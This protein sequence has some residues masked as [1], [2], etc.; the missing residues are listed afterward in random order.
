MNTDNV[1][2]LLDVLECHHRRYGAS[3]ISA[4][5][6]FAPYRHGK[7]KDLRA[8]FG[9]LVAHGGESRFRCLA[10]NMHGNLRELVWQLEKYRGSG[11]WYAAAGRLVSRDDMPSVEQIDAKI[12]SATPKEWIVE[13]RGTPYWKSP[14]PPRLGAKLETLQYET[15]PETDLDRF[16]DLSEEALVYLTGPR[17]RLTA[18]TIAEFELGW[19][20]GRRRV[21]VPIRDLQRQ[22][23][24]ITG[25][26]LD[27]FDPEKLK[28]VNEQSPKFLHSS[29]FHRDYFLFGEHLAQ[30]GQVGHLVEGHFDAIFLRQ[31]GFTNA[32]AVMGSYLSPWQV[33]KLVKLCSRVVI[34][35]DGDKAGEQ[36]AARWCLSLSG[37][38][39][40]AM[41]EVNDERDPDEYSV[42]ELRQKLAVDNLKFS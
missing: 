41:A 18:P 33:E 11:P 19:H 20:A 40:V 3:W 8:S 39:P 36:A 16:H 32:L 10:C 28:W 21:V 30:A 23:V 34:L 9:I 24:G 6:P 26:C 27:Y 22:L 12:G 7:G 25:R 2:K 37:R 13:V 4:S 5:C 29:G 1:E 35:R 14:E 38:V 42:A 15:I 17:R 31:C